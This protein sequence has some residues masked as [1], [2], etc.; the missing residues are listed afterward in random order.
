[1][2]FHLA[3]WQMFSLSERE[4]EISSFFPEIVYSFIFHANN[5]INKSSGC[6]VASN[7]RNNLSLCLSVA[8]YIPLEWT[9]DFDQTAKHLLLFPGLLFSLSFSRYKT[10]IIFNLFFLP[11]KC[12]RKQGV[13]EYSYLWTWRNDP[14]IIWFGLNDTSR[15]QVYTFAAIKTKKPP[16]SLIYLRS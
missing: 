4:R 12:C 8:L 16:N 2:G 10:K 3:P 14:T 5:M 13:S 6:N 9:V 7:D 15:I 1:M 11:Y